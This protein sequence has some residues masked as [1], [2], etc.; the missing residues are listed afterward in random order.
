MRRPSWLTKASLLITGTAQDPVA[1]VA[2]LRDED[3]VFWI[4]YYEAWLVTRHDDVRALFAD[5]RV[6]TDA[7]A[8]ER[9][10]PSGIAGA[11]RWLGAMPFRSMQSDPQSV[12]RRLAMGVLTP[13]AVER[14]EERI[15]EV[16]EQ[17]A[18]PLRSR[19]D[20]VDLMTEFTTPISTMAIGRILGVPPKG[21]DE[22]RF[23]QLA[24]KA[25]RGIRPFLSDE[26]RLKSERSAV[27]MCEYVSELVRERRREPADDMISDLLGASRA[28]SSDEIDDVVR[29]VAA[30]VSAGTGTVGTACARALRTLLLHP[31]QLCQLRS[32]RSLLPNAVDELLRYD[33]GLAVVPRYAL[34]DFELRGRAIKKGQLV[35]PC[36]LAANRDPDVFTDPDRLDLGRDCRQALSFGYGPHYCTGTGIARIEMRLMLDAALDFLPPRAR[37]LT[38]QIRWSARGMMAQIR[39]LPVDF[40]A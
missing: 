27:E 29:I 30:L 28:T 35:A 14:T 15:R 24:V 16:V 12:P 4:P 2:K 38:D 25:T 17:C 32:D 11:A 40:G 34:E 26:K 33:S 31:A 1:F 8:Y 21:A 23:R 10:I 39:S 19:S 6:T 5:A 36:I 13:R 37:L 3:P 7:R 20:V 22:I 18:A 9:H